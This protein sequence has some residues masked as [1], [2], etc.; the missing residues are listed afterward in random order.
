V[1][2]EQ[3]CE[4]LFEG[5]EPQEQS[6]ILLNDFVPDPTKRSHDHPGQYRGEQENILFVL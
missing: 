1:G 3:T 4:P 2:R 5:L 6:S